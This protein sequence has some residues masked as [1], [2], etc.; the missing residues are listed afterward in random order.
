MEPENRT[1]IV[2]YSKHH[3]NTQLLVDAIKKREPAVALMN[4]SEISPYYLSDFDRIGIASGIYYSRFAKP[5]M[6][7]LEVHLPEN[8]KVFAMFTCGQMNSGYTKGVKALAEKRNCEYL[9][10]YGCLG[11]DTF[12][13]FKLMGGISKGHPSITEITGAVDFYRSLGK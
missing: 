13:P 4:I 5:L 9:G 8:K 11:F 12:G 7:Y 10:E 6:K 1:I 2:F 3:R